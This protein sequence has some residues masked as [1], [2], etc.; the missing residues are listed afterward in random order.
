MHMRIWKTQGVAD[1]LITSV[2]RT[3]IDNILLSMPHHSVL[4]RPP[5]V[6]RECLRVSSSCSSGTDRDVSR[7]SF[8]GT[9]TGLLSVWQSSGERAFW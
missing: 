1:E 7:R 8:G 2:E 5:L 3:E 4:A 9:A 6:A